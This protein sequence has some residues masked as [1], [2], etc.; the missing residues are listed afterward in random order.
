VEETFINLTSEGKIGNMHAWCKKAK[1]LARGSKFCQKYNFETVDST[2]PGYELL[3][4]SFDGTKPR[5]T[6]KANELPCVFITES[7]LL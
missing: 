2:P 1:T 7:L 4:L 6:P 5:F 3:A